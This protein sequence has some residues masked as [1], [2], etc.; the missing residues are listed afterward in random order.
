MTCILL[1][2]LAFGTF[3]VK[4]IEGKIGINVKSP[5]EL[6]FTPK[7]LSKSSLCLLSE[8]NHSSIILSDVFTQ[9]IVPLQSSVTILDL[10]KFSDNL[11]LQKNSRNIQHFE[12]I[13]VIYEKVSKVV[14]LSFFQFRRR[15]LINPQLP[16]P[17]HS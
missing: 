11:F 14:S 4:I 15:N 6:K 8:G 1:L 12:T 10:N 9:I 13:S 2:F 3:T 16:F 7:I 5:E 17:G